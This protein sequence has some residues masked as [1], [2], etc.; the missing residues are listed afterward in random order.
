MARE[1]HRCSQI[2]LCVSSAI[3]LG[4]RKGRRRS[5]ENGKFTMASKKKRPP[6]N[7]PP[8][9]R[10]TDDPPRKS[11]R[12]TFRYEGDDVELISAKR[13]AMTPPPSEPLGVQ[14]PRSGFCVELSTPRG[15]VLYRRFGTNPIQTSVEAP[16]DD[17]DRPFQR[18]T[19]E[20]PTGEFDVVVPDM[21]DAARLDL[22]GD[23]RVESKKKGGA[24]KKADAE[25]RSGVSLTTLDLRK[26]Q[27]GGEMSK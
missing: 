13:V 5:T 14:E 27:S 6:T 24:K 20:S 3:G 11:L 23:I 1:T 25:F 16:S 19:V 2:G 15:R 8:A 18:A 12:L 17:P 10:R 22:L 7:K 21:E 4:Q 26:L 9:V